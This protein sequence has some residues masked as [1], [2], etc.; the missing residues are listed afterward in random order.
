[1]DWLIPIILPSVNLNQPLNFVRM[2]NLATDHGLEDNFAVRLASSCI[3]YCR[4][5]QCCCNMLTTILARILVSV[6]Y[7]ASPPTSKVRV[8]TWAENSLLPISEYRALLPRLAVILQ[9]RSFCATSAR[10]IKVHHG[11]L[12]CPRRRNSL[13]VE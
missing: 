5:P 12:C 10:F 2:R 7:C 13:H 1:M 11:W 3:S 8:R 4:L 9:L 6:L